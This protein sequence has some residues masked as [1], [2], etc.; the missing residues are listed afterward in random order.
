MKFP[1]SV[2]LAVVA[3]CLCASWTL[4]V[5]AQQ[6]PPAGQPPQ[7]PPAIPQPKPA[8]PASP[9]E[10]VPQ[11]PAGQPPALP[12]AAGQQPQRPQLEAP[13]TPAQPA[14]NPNGQV[15]ETIEFRGAKRVPQDTLKALILSKVGDI[16]NEETLRRDYMILWNT[17]RFDDIRLESEPGRTGFLCE[18]ND[19]WRDALL[20]LAREPGMRKSMGEAGARMEDVVRTRTYVVNIARDWEHIGRAHGEMFS[21]IRPA[22]TMVEVRSLIDP[23][24]LVEI[25]AE[26]IVIG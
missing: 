14:A 13:P 21:A 3:A 1:R 19:Q 15:I 8:T 2:R 17:G 16:Y 7:T 12:P 9:F 26:A 22:A 23:K 18:T 25:E 4:P 6:Q 10:T 20:R 5:S 24:M 11:L